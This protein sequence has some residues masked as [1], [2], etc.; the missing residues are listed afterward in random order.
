FLE[1][2][3][4][5]GFRARAISQRSCRGGTIVVDA[6]VVGEPL[7][8]GVL[9]GDDRFAAGLSRQ[10]LNLCLVAPQAVDLVHALFE[11][12][13]PQYVADALRKRPCG[14]GIRKQSTA[15]RLRQAALGQ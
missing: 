12:G 2:E 3:Y 13:Q 6:E 10:D 1:A 9:D 11:I 5:I 14:T 15:A 8:V 7:A 4:V